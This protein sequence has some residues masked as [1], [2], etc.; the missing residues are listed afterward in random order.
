MIDNKTIDKLLPEIC[1][2]LSKL[3]QFPS[4]C[5]QEHQAM[6]FL[7][8]QFGKIKNAQVEKIF[9]S[10]KIKEDDDY[11]SPIPDITYNGRFNLR[12]V[13]KGK[14]S[15]K[16]ILLNAHT[17][18]VPVS[19]GMQD[20]FS[21]KFENGI[22]YG[23]GSCDDKGS[24]ATIYFLFKLLEEF[25][26]N[27]PCDL[28]AHL[29][30]EE[31]NGG[32]GSLAMARTNEKAD[33]CIVLEPTEFN[34]LTSI[35]GAVWFKIEFFGK[36]GHSGQAGKTRSAL[37][38]AHTAITALTQYHKELLTN[39]KGIALFDKYENP[40]PIT[41][42]KL[43]AGNWPASAPSVAVLEGVLGFLPNKTKE[44]IVSEMNQILL[45]NFSSDDFKLTF[46]YRHNCS[47]TD[48]QQ[49][50]VQELL[51]ANKSTNIN[52][53]IDAMPAS[54]DAWFYNNQNNIPTVVYGPGTLKVAHSKDEH[55]KL[56]DIVDAAKALL[57]FSM[58]FSGS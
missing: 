25:K 10:D 1:D 30:V 9:L 40:M 11:S 31:E 32:N 21:G 6:E 41:F 17:D 52:S 8:E 33:C 27:L 7:Y 44:E 13:C 58:N 23:R 24:V 57:V 36:A 20:A 46:T 50:F 26:I 14:P 5:G 54:C 22:F 34:V 48:P 4:T 28:I 37:L 42:G 15:G 39:S 19:E 2:F 51:K 55:I 29:V 18:V 53:E 45:N 16:K 43:Q 38:M 47:V 3:L 12:V 35:R 56:S 49:K